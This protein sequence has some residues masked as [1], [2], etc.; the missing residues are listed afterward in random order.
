MQKVLLFVSVLLSAL[1]GLLALPFITRGF[2]EAELALIS[3]IL[4]FNGLFSVF[5]F[6]RPVY[7]SHFSKGGRFI[8]FA[9]VVITSVL[10]VLMIG[11]IF[12]PIYV[13][14][15]S[16]YISVVSYLCVFFSF[17][18]FVVNVGLWA[19]LDVKQKVG[20]TS[21]LRTLGTS[22]VYLFFVF[23]S[24]RGQK[25]IESFSLA[26]LLGQGFAF[27]LSLFFS[28]N[29]LSFT[30]QINIGREFYKNGFLTLLQNLSKAVIDFS[31]RLF[32]ANFCAPVLVG[33]YNIFYDLTSRAN[34]PSQIVSTYYYPKMCR[35]GEDIP[36]FL[37]YGANMSAL[38]LL[39]SWVMWLFG[40]IVIEVYL[41]SQVMKYW[42]LFPIMIVSWSVFSLAFFA[43]AALR[44][45]GDYGWLLSSFTATALL[46]LLSMYPLYVAMGVPGVL[47]S[48]I[49]MKMP[50]VLGYWRLKGSVGRYKGYVVSLVA[51]QIFS[52]V[53]FLCFM[54]EV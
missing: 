46:G 44:A 54:G 40:D 23:V 31:D 30:C 36:R 28:A 32:I 11:P 33:I 21:V 8:S 29:A 48:V 19:A 24:L 26:L 34:I 42:E 17:V 3:L 13:Y 4:L 53:W 1:V 38:V 47:S 5:D 45:K 10:L 39:A 9:D 15:F 2:E 16:E 41:G 43:Q 49:M 18:I 14:I 22:F 35:D 27:L 12:I 51:A 7:I 6:F 25:S 50:G 52:F 37:F 20:L